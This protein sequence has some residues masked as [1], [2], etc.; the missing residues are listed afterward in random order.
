MRYLIVTLALIVCLDPSRASAQTRPTLR[1]EDLEAR[2]A[3]APQIAIAED[4]AAAQRYA[5]DEAEAKGGFTLNGGLSAGTF[6]EP[7]T[8]TSDRAYRSLAG[9]LSVRYPL[10]GERSATRAAVGVERATLLQRNVDVAI[11][12]AQVLQELR[13]RYV[14]Y[15]AATQK[16]ALGDDLLRDEQATKEALVLRRRA[17]LV[18]HSDEIESTTTFELIRRNEATFARDKARALGELQIVTGSALGSFDPVDP[19][20][21]DTCPSADVFG[22]TAINRSAKVAAYREAATTA[23]LLAE[24]P[25]NPLRGGVSVGKSIALQRPATGTASGT[26]IS[27][28]VSLPLN[29]QR[30]NGVSQRKFA[31]LADG[32]KRESDLAEARIA[33]EA[34]DAWLGYQ[35]AKI[36]L[37]FAELRLHAADVAVHET[38]LRYGKLPSVTI[39]VRQRSRAL[40]YAAT[41]DELDA[42]SGVYRQQAALR[43]Y[44]PDGCAP[45]AGVGISAGFAAY[46]WKARNVLGAARLEGFWDRLAERG[47]NRFLLS[48]EPAEMAGLRSPS[49]FRTRVIAFISDAARHGV[50][51]ELLLGEPSWILP[52]RRSDLVT[53][54]EQVR[55][56]PFAGIELDMEPDQLHD[57]TLTKSTAAV[58]MGRSAVAAAAAARVPVGVTVHV[59][60][61]E[62]DS[63][64]CLICELQTGGIK[65][66]T[67]MAYSTNPDLVARRMSAILHAHPGMRFALAQSVEPELPNTESYAGVS[68]AAF[69]DVVERLQSGIAATNFAG[70]VV[71]TYDDYV[72]LPQ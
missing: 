65:R 67:A 36:N 56:V 23:A 41:I 11:A 45:S 69:R 46:A 20:F 25:A 27:V 32:A 30:A 66:V 42:R 71:E 37:V 16:D 58:E 3:R 35:Q 26:T 9:Q 48:F 31:V 4:A 28:D 53:I 29:G 51:V 12:R 68:R 50:P 17:G 52:D 6:N 60:Y 64:S 21:G 59:R 15:W 49:A 43:F 13:T 2:L 57:A 14:E 22:R 47:V 1:V 19:H 70:I 33:A 55:D 7:V 5:I 34:Y 62:D 10:F 54:V 24:K 39:E 63:S 38:N 18:L 8:S 72:N 61:L 44:A 40:Q